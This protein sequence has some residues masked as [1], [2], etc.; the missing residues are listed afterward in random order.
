MRDRREGLIVPPGDPGAIASAVERVIADPVA[1]AAR[2]AAARRRVETDLSFERR[3]RALESIYRELAEA[4][5]AKRNPA[6]V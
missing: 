4:R 5:R 6:Y 3:L 2:V 1:T